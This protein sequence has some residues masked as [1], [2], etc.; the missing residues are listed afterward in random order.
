MS[1]EEITTN[2]YV[3]YNIPVILRVSLYYNVIVLS[4]LSG[5]Y[6]IDVLK[7]FFKNILIILENILGMYCKAEKSDIETFLLLVCTSYIALRISNV[8]KIYSM[9]FYDILRTFSESICAM[10]DP[11]T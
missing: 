4:V 8:R 10:W 3:A 7:I 9:Y 2:I 11:N 6:T 1:R 5:I